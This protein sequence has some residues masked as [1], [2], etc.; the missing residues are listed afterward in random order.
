MHPHDLWVLRHGETEWNR[1]HRWQG[2]LDSPLTKAGEAQAR[3]LGILLHERGATPESHRFVTSPQ[4]RAARSAA[5][6]LEAIGSDRTAGQDP[7]LSEIDVGEWTGLTRAEIGGAP[8]GVG[9]LDL[10]ARAPGGEDFGAL[11][12]RVRAVLS[13]ARGAG[14]RDHPRHHLALPAR[15]RDGVGS[16]AR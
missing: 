6:I 5:L 13:V 4:G 2:R 15:R 1:A 14:G 7:R 16:R 9:F 10:Y 3:R 12:A 8:P 11:D